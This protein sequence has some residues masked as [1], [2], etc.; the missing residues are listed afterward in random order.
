MYDSVFHAQKPLQGCGQADSEFLP[1]QDLASSAKIGKS[2]ATHNAV[3]VLEQVR[4]AS[5]KQRA[6]VELQRMRSEHIAYELIR[7]V[8]PAEL[9]KVST[10]KY[11]PKIPISLDQLRTL[12]LKISLREFCLENLI[13]A[14]KRSDVQP[15]KNRAGPRQQDTE[16]SPKMESAWRKRM[17]GESLPKCFRGR[18]H[19]LCWRIGSK[20]AAESSRTRADSCSTI[21]TS[22]CIPTFPPTMLSIAG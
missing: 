1:R 2:Y 16:K 11:F 7:N 4:P 6:K 14:E 5:V 15:P 19:W 13:P 21:W 9:R 10:L 22:L 12:D 3:P 20:A 8:F 18:V 17:A